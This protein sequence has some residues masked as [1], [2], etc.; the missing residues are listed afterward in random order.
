M[1]ELR[2]TGRY[3]LCARAGF[4]CQVIDRNSASLHRAAIITSTRSTK[5]STSKCFQINPSTAASASRSPRGNFG[6]TATQTLFNG[7]QTANGAR[8]AERQVAGARETLRV[9]EQQVLLDA[10]TSYMN[11]LRDQGDP[12]S[13]SPQRRSAHR[14]TETNP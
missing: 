3:R 14:A 1:C 13:Q 7:F 12:R 10:A 9:T 4:S 11:L 8:R 5:R 2:R 6:A